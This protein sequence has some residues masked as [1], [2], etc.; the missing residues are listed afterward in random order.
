[1]QMLMAMMMTTMMIRL[2]VMMMMMGSTTTT[3]TKCRRRKIE[4]AALIET[5]RETES[6]REREAGGRGEKGTETKFSWLA[7]WHLGLCL[8]LCLCPCLRL[9]VFA[10]RRGTA[11]F[12]FAPRLHL[13]EWAK[14][15]SYHFHSA[16]EMWRQRKRSEW[17]LIA[18]AMPDGVCA[19]VCA[20][21]SYLYISVHVCVTVI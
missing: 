20:C 15:G 11:D 10:Y 14:K 13:L 7:G 9:G 16:T 19:S 2:M 8:C 3:T 4:D 12:C 1:M 18:I 17:Y 21:V 6:E 5:E